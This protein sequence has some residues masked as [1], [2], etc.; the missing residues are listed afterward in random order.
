[1][2]PV[3]AFE[4]GRRATGA[5]RAARASEREQSSR[6]LALVTATQDLQRGRRKRG[7]LKRLVTIVPVSDY[8]DVV[9]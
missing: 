9:G 4:Q 6:R 5:P 1:M 3:R 2:P 7:R 8:R